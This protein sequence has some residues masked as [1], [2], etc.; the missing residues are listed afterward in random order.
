MEDEHPEIPDMHRT[1]HSGNAKAGRGGRPAKDPA[2]I[3]RIFKP[4]LSRVCFLFSEILRRS[5]LTYL[6][7]PV[8]CLA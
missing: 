6:G 2:V 5:R 3:A 7:G 1:E 4:G 8:T